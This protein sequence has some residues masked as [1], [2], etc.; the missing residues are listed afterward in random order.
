MEPI[1][2]LIDTGIFHG[3]TVEMD[4]SSLKKRLLLHQGNASL[5][6]MTWSAGQ[7]EFMPLLLALYHLLPPS[8][9]TQ[10]TG[11]EWVIVEEPEMGLHP[12]AIRS[13]MV[14]FLELIQRGYKLVIST[15]SPMLLELMW[16]MGEI[17]ALDGTSDDLYKLFDLPKT[18]GLTKIFKSAIAEKRFAT[19]YFD[20]RSDG[21]HIKDISSLDAGADDGAIA[22]WGGI[23][24][25]A[26]R[27]AE[28]VARLAAKAN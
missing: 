19:Y 7:K 18:L 14:V 17:Q 9:I 3:A 4:R 13:L 5:P 23:S 16:A 28:I 27:A 15:H 6:F 24:E 21:V 2:E 10:R 1:R 11:V 8:K 12:Q 26:G 25:F 22:N 20:R